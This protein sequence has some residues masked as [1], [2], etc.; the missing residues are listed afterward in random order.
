MILFF[1]LKSLL[2]KIIFYVIANLKYYIILVN[3]I[4]VNEIVFLYQEI[5]L[6]MFKI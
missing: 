3:I 6:F 5:I 2:F 1:R 4:L